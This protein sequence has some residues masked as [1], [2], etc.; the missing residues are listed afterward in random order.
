MQ[1]IDA[2]P[3]ENSPTKIADFVN[4]PFAI[5]CILMV[6]HEVCGVFTML[7]YASVIF[8]KAGSSLEPEMAAIIVGAIQL[9]GSYVSSL[10]ID[11]L[12]RKVI[13]Y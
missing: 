5:C 6:A 11:N 10:L 2:N 3:T 7:N 12:G 9:A 13:L 1:R 4:R 8:K